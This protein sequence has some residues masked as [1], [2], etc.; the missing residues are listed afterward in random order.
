M[1]HKIL[2]IIKIRYHLSIQILGRWI[3]ILKKESVDGM[4]LDLGVSSM[5]LDRPE[6]GFSFN[7]EGPLDMRMDPSQRLDA[8]SVVNSFSEKKLGEIFRDFGEEPR[9]RRA[10]AAIVEAR[11]KKR[12]ETTLDL[13]EAL[14]PVLTWG[15]MRG[16][17]N[18]SDDFGFSSSAYLRQR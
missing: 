17:K 11:R 5:Q 1:R 10:A 3:N 13:V 4:F 9:W 7:K 14:K 16:K 8:K 15:G 18:S 6:K 2:Q 12:I